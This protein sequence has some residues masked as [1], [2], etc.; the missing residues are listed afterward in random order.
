LNNYDF[1]QKRLKDEQGMKVA[2]CNEEIEIEFSHLLNP[3]LSVAIS[4]KW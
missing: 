3:P 2:P 4:S 1:S